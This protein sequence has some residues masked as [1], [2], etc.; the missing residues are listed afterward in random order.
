MAVFTALSEKAA[1]EHS[2]TIAEVVGLAA[3]LAGLSPTSHNHTL[4]S[5]SGVSISS[6][7]NGHALV[8]GG[9]VWSNRALTI[10]DVTNLTATL[11]SLSRQVA[12]IDGGAF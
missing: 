2:H 1:T 8:Y 11:S 6:P 12:N 9:S 3:A 5:L 10:G 4:A 7:A